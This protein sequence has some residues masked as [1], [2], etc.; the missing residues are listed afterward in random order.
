MLK[1]TYTNEGTNFYAYA[2]SCSELQR[3]AVCCSVCC[4][5]SVWG[6]SQSAMCVCI[7]MSREC[8]MCCSVLQCVAVCCSV[9]QCVAVCCSALQFVAVWATCCSVLQCP[10]NVSMSFK[11]IKSQLLHFK[12]DFHEDCNTLHCNTLQHAATCCNMLQHTSRLTSTKIVDADSSN[13]ALWNIIFPAPDSS[14]WWGFYINSR[15]WFD[16]CNSLGTKSSCF[17]TCTTMRDVKST[18]AGLFFLV[19]DF[20]T[21]WLPRRFSC[22]CMWLSLECTATHGNTRQHTATHC[23]ILQ[24]TATHCNALKHTATHCNT[25][26]HTA[27]QWCQWLPLEGNPNMLQHAATHCNTLQ[28]TATHCNTLRHTEPHCTTLHHTAPHC[29]MWQPFRCNSNT[30]QHTTTHCNTL[31]D[32]APYCNTLQHT[33]L[34]SHL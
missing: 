31:Q 1:L 23:N 27:A 11:K 2:V 15:L 29:C 34:C 8:A 4:N 33:V 17:L 18:S 6:D 28:H 14:M 9:L 16:L 19:D 5:G 10:G 20:D 13:V 30:L 3:V 21:L 25:L 32:T 22:C 12:T 24:H 26:Q 7:F